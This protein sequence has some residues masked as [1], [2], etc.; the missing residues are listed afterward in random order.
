MGYHSDLDRKVTPD[1]LNSHRI[2]QK[3]EAQRQREELERRAQQQCVVDLKRA[4]NNKIAKLP[5][6]SAQ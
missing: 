3:E 2:F 6:D 1:E 5:E 4:T